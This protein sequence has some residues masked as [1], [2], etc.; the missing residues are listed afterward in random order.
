MSAIDLRDAFKAGVMPDLDT[1]LRR[2]VMRSAVLYFLSGLSFAAGAIATLVLV[3]GSYS[4]R[5][6]RTVA[7]QILQ[8]DV[9]VR[10]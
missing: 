8:G 2:P 10:N 5:R 9:H 6:E 3:T 1:E 7:L 4:E